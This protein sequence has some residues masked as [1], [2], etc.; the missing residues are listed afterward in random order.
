MLNTG[1]TGVDSKTPDEVTNRFALAIVAAKLLSGD[2]TNVGK[3]QA[4]DQNFPQ[5]KKKIH[6]CY[7][8]WD[9]TLKKIIF[10]Y[11]NILQTFLDDWVDFSRG[12]FQGELTAF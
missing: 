2:N 4:V 9:L 12:N 10:S 6:R 8:Y 7:F 5:V 3:W 11:F 1:P